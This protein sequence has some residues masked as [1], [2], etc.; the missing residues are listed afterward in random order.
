ME[1]PKSFSV[2]AGCRMILR[3]VPECWRP[4]RPFASVEPHASVSLT[5]RHSRDNQVVALCR[6]AKLWEPHAALALFGWI[7]IA[8]HPRD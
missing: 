1:F 4:V 8:G 3:R 6:A 7:A 5:G 2:I